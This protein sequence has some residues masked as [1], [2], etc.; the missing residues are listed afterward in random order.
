M[1]APSQK[2]AELEREIQAKDEQIAD[3]QAELESHQVNYRS[4]GLTKSSSASS[5][6]IIT[7]QGVTPMQL[8][9]ALKNVGFDPGPVDGRL[10]KQTVDAI[11]RFQKHQGLKADGVVGQ[12]TWSL[13]KS[14]KR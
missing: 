14:K 13:L 10:G 11:K 12:K 3:L 1:I 2:I 4:E 6:Q 5:N 9:K 7:V 8:Q